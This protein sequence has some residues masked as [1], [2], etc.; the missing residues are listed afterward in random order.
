M[1]EAGRAQDVE[2]IES[3]PPAADKH[4][5]RLR[6]RLLGTAFRPRF[7]AGQPVATADVAYR[8]TYTP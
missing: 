7:D 4:V 6:K 8:Y 1:N 2:V 3:S 5:S